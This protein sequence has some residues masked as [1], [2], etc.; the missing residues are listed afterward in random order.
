VSRFQ[1]ATAGYRENWLERYYVISRRQ[2]LFAENF[3][4]TNA[5]GVRIDGPGAGENMV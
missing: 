2:N 4:R 1:F 5:P 3:Y